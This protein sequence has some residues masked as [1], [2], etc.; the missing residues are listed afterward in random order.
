[1]SI[2]PTRQAERLNIPSRQAQLVLQRAA[3]RLSACSTD[4]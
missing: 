1:V 4:I 3:D 2:R